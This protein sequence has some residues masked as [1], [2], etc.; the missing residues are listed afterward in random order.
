MSK[1][2]EKKDELNKIELGKLKIEQLEKIFKKYESKELLSIVEKT[3]YKKEYYKSKERVRLGF[4]IGEDAAAIDMGN[5]YL[6]CKTDPI[7]FATEDIGYYVVNVNSND[8]ATMGA[9][10]KWFQVSILLPENTTTE[11]Y[12]EKICIDI[13]KCC[14]EKGIVLVGG[15]TEVTYG[16]DRPIVIGSMFGEVEKDKLVTTSGGKANDAIL[17]TKAIPLEGLSII[18]REKADYLKERGIPD[19]IINR[20]RKYLYDP[21]ISVLKEALLAA[22]NFSI[23][24]M[25]DPTEGGLATGLVELAKSSRCGFLVDEKKIPK[26][27]ETDDIC[28]IFGL[29]PLCLIS[30]GTL[31]I[32]LEEKDAISL[33]SLLIKNGI[34]C[35]IIGK[36]TKEEK[37]LIKELNGAIKPLS[38]SEKDEI[39]KIF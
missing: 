4:A 35:E 37:Y 5:K 39:T 15:H 22:K 25:H 16:L 19:E 8:I 10:P 13:Q 33:K 14:L 29:N 3:P 2:N 23:H 11:S 18:A 20:C 31:L 32:V 36:L 21:G 17:L 28:S 7:T 26:L 30:S 12:V 34:N 38:Y 27:P 24:A 6:I 9:I 1:K